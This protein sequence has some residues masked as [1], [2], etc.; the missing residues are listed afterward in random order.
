MVE[1]E[2]T[3]T[4]RSSPAMYRPAGTHQARKRQGSIWLTI[5]A[6]NVFHVIANQCGWDVNILTDQASSVGSRLKAST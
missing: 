4:A 3:A 6:S 1:D 2:E 5:T